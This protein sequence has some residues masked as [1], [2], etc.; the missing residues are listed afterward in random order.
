MS[1]VHLYR[2]VKRHY[3]IWSKASGRLRDWEAARV[4]KNHDFF[5]NKK[6]LIFL[7]KS[8]FFY[9]FFI[10]LIF[11][12]S[13]I[14]N[15]IKYFTIRLS[16]VNTATQVCALCAFVLKNTQN[17]VDLDACKQLFVLNSYKS[18]IKK[19]GSKKKS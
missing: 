13:G 9:L 4:E 19:T 3:A 2:F 18:A 1:F 5:L 12:K 16:G 7:C 10:Y 8:D 14:H 15:V 11:F 6:N 17:F